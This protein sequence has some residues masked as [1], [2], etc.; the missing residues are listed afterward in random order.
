MDSIYEKIDKITKSNTTP[1]RQQHILNV[2]NLAKELGRKYGVD[3]EKLEIAA[4]CH[5]MARVHDV[6]VNDKYIID[7]ALDKKYL[8]NINLAHSKIAAKLAKNLGINDEDVLNAISYHT[9]GRANMSMM[10]KIV[11]IADAIEP[12]RDYPG[13]DEIREI[14]FNNIDLACLMSLENTIEHLENQ[15]ITDID[16]DTIKARDYFKALLK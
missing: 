11:F 10:E 14:V 16:D 13:V 7:L 9:T 2:A 15:G 3:E 12:K 4:L 5:D 6:E 1:K 8:G